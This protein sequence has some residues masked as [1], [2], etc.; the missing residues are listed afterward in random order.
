[1]RAVGDEMWAVVFEASFRTSF[2]ADRAGVAVLVVYPS[3]E[4]RSIELGF[5]ACRHR[6][7]FGRLRLWARRS[8]DYLFVV[9]AKV[10]Q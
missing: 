6:L 8:G 9:V 7:E 2:L 3:T 10:F 4:A 5:V 1:M